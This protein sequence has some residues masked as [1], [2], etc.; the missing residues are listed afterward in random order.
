MPT[1]TPHTIA[2]AAEW[3]RGKRVSS[4]EL[5]RELLGRARAVQETVGAFM[6]VTED[7]ALEAA[8]RADDEIGRGMDRG[9]L[10]G[11]PL[12]IKDILATADAPTMAN[13]RVLDPAWGQRQDATV[14][15]K[16]RA[17]GAVILGK[18]VLHEFAIGWPDPATGLR[19]ARNPWDLARSPGGS[20][21]GTGAAI[22]AGLILGGLGTDTGGS[23][24]APAAYC[25]ISGLKPTF[26]RVSNEGCV[27]LSYSLDHIGPMARSMRDCAVLLQVLA[28]FDPLDPCTVR[29]AVP[30]YA[31]ELN[32]SVRD[33]RIGLMR[34]YFF[35]VPE[36]DAEVRQ[37][38]LDGVDRL[39][40]AGAAVVDVALPHAAIARHAQRA[41]MF[42]E[43]Y[44]YHLPDLQSRPQ[45]YGKYTRQQI[46]QGALYS[47][48]DYV[49]AQRVRSVI[50]AEALAALSTVD[51]LVTP[52]ML[53]VAPT[54]EGYDP[55]AMRRA[56][57]FTAIWN[58]TGL[59]AASVCCG[60]SNAG[61]PIGMQIVGKPFDEAMVL[62]VG[63]AYQQV[64]DWHTRTPAAARQV[65]P[66]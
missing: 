36:L 23:I 16:L 25:G 10:H 54:F 21:S 31:A 12:G 63:D 18:L 11:I 3:L 5:T 32:G 41:I 55:D 15:R 33:L 29:V 20:S 6:T 22:A 35:D 66:A 56:P 52:T 4:L 17:A 14:V 57:T 49:Q 9:P 27:P 46:V 24:R 62:R 44:A 19:Y 13:S 47:G 51:V 64:T 7:A 60:F 42:S 59:P 39:T 38:V 43:A 1:D 45:L 26:G 48:A 65:Q 37:A 8:R 34:E 28:G 30:D 50:K 53:N 61:L 2:K 58:L 40:A